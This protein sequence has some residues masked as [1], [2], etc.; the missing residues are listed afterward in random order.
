MRQ[1]RLRHILRERDIRGLVNEQVLSVYRD[2]GVIP[3]DSRDDNYNKTP[4]NLQGYKLVEA[5]DIVVN[6]MKAWQGSVALSGYR[7]I[8]S[9]DYL[10]CSIKSS[11]IIPRF[12]HYLLRSQAL[13]DEYR[14]RSSGVRPAQWRLYWDDLADI[15]IG[16]PDPAAQ[17]AIADYLDAE[18]ARI[19]ALITKKRRMIELLE[20]R[21][22]VEIERVLGVDDGPDDS[23][24]PLR[25]L[26]SISGGLTL[27]NVREG[28]T[29][30]R[31]YLRV[32]N[33]QDGWLDLTDVTDIE[34]P[35]ALAFRYELRYGDVLMLEGNGNP[36]NLGRGTIWRD[37]INGCLH[38][39]HIHTVRASRQMDAEFLDRLVRS[40]WARSWFTAS[41]EQVSIATLS[42]DKI[43][44]LRVPLPT[45]TEQKRRASE[46]TAIRRRCTLLTAALATQSQLL[47]EHRQAL[48][49]AAVTGELEVSGAA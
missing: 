16:V 40:Q 38:Q 30:R 7:G 45:L 46:V 8:V 18:T 1:A 6:K 31:P 9:G 2:H 49:T 21:S 32:T 5:G 44:D 14:K 34:I 41:S 22:K 12:L 17:H 10:V 27:G 35:V 13:I 24:V 20:E 36:E 42:Q 33:V 19:D 29:I 48:I 4:E 39:N 11:T 47:A 28:T 26:V 37:E 15:R 25:Y 23:W 3:K 43:K